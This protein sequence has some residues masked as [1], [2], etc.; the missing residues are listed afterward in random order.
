MK[1]TLIEFYVREVYGTR[2]EY[3]KNA[4]DARIIQQLT[5]KK[6]ITSITRELIRDLSRGQIQ[7]VQ[8]LNWLSRS[9]HLTS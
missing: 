2:L 4:A 8:V 5:G 9:N 3:V 6:T 1:K 7:F